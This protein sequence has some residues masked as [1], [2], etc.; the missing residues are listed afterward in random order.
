MQVLWI[1]KNQKIIDI[2]GSDTMGTSMR[3]SSKSACYLA[4]YLM[5][6]LTLVLR[7]SCKMKRKLILCPTLRNDPF[8]SQ[9]KL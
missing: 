4:K 3:I 1:Q 2:K 8:P 9:F 6:F 7:R 5:G